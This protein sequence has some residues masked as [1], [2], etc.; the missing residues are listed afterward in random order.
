VEG[1]PRFF[2]LRKRG[3]FDKSMKKGKP[4]KPRLAAK[5]RR[6]REEGRR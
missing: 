6:L 3:K 5:Y 2:K 4:E 1:K